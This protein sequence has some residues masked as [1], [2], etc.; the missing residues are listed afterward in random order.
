MR[1][2]TELGDMIRKFR[3]IKGMK[4]YELADKVGIDA[5]YLTQIERQG[6]FPSAEKMIL[7]ANCI[8]PP[9]STLI[10]YKYRKFKGLANIDTWIDILQKRELKET[11][12]NAPFLGYATKIKCT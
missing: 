6:R 9:S 11:K 5:A 7:I 1:K 2:S 3:K 10:L 12:A 8:E 4:V